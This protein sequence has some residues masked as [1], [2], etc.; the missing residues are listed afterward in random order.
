MGIWF[1][2]ISVNMKLALGFGL[3]LS[4]TAILAATG[5]TSLSSLIVRSD[6]I[7]DITELNNLLTKLRLANLQYMMSNGDDAKAQE[8][9]ADLDG[10]THQQQKLMQFF[11]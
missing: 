10:F 11:V 4:L 1:A 8:M 9:Q 7:S 6:R 2:N 3:V 5:W